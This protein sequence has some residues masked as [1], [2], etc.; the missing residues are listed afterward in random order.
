MKALTLDEA[1]EAMRGKAGTPLPRLSIT[2]VTTD[3][4]T[5]RPG[6]LFVALI[7]RRFDGHDFVNEAFERGATAA[8]VSRR[9]M[10]AA[11]FPRPVICVPDTMT[12]LGDLAA[13]YRRQIPATVIAVTG[14]N[15]KTTTRQMIHHVLAGRRRGRQAQRSF[16]NQVGVPLTLLSAEGADEF[17][18]LEL[19]SNH[20]GEIDALAALARPDMGVLVSIGPAHLEGLGDLGGVT[21]EKTSLFRRVRPGGLAVVNS[22]CLDPSADLPE[23]INL[24]VVTF[25]ETA[26]A[27][28]RLTRFAQKS[29]GIAF[30]YNGR[31]EVD[32]PVLGKHNALNA[33]AVVVVAR[34]L[35]VHDAE[36][37]QR[38]STFC[39]PEMRLQPLRLGQVEIIF[40]AYNANPASVAAA[41]EVWDALPSTSRRVLVFGDMG[42]LGP[43]SE[44]LHR[45]IGKRIA[46]ARMDALV[47]V[48]PL[49]RATAEQCPPRTPC[50]HYADASEAARHLETWLRPG[51]LVLIKGSR[52]MKLERIV[53]EL[54]R[55]PDRAGTKACKTA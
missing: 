8:V 42:E 49:S 43:Q 50:H 23:D 40:D 35:S 53:A 1:V 16:N 55:R 26:G 6:Q 17:L 37:A 29:R 13:Y 24:N 41:L 20:P 2:G 7:G 39:S 22:D 14:S 34:R 19:G 36:I 31:F 47:T 21:R 15:G 10:F 54:R 12:A 4:R 51:D 48:G 27:D 3:S 44:A 33:L 46:A 45:A 25:G 18:V 9:E 52:A 28:V 32:M 11:D 30:Q 38:L 5:A